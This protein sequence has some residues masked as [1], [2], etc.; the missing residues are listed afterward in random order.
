[1]QLQQRALSSLWSLA[2]MTTTTMAMAK[3]LLM[4]MSSCPPPS[5]DVDDADDVVSIEEH[6]GLPRDWPIVVDVVSFCFKI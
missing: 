2:M 5:I 6:S 4:T 1:M 3:I